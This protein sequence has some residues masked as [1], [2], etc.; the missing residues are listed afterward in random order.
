MDI[1][2]AL[3]A[4]IAQ[5]EREVAM[6]NELGPGH[7]KLVERLLAGETVHQIALR[8][9][10][11]TNAK[12][13]RTNLKAALRKLGAAGHGDPA[14]IAEVTAPAV[15]TGKFPRHYLP[16]RSRIR[17]AACHPLFETRLQS[18]DPDAAAL[19]ELVFTM[20]MQFADL[21]AVAGLPLADARRMLNSAVRILEGGEPPKDEAERRARSRESQRRYMA[22]HPDRAGEAQRRYRLR[23]KQKQMVAKDDLRQTNDEAARPDDASR[24]IQAEESNSGGRAG[25]WQTDEQGNQSISAAILGGAEG[26]HR[27]EG[28]GGVE[29]DTLLRGDRGE[30]EFR[31]VRAA[32]RP[33]QT[34]EGCAGLLPA[35]A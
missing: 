32:A 5:W 31:A 19:V 28:Q 3:D 13:H 27:P 8:D 20:P 1:V 16:A 11:G 10:Y 34:D 7:R 4:C 25:R 30:E 9:G 14:V 21:A 15:S 6:L 2:A 22:A 23:R 35:L 18:L 33:G 17:K 12:A 24:Q 26:V 29:G